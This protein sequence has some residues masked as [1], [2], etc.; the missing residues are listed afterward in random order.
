ML[1]SFLADR[2]SKNVW[3]SK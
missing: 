1:V 3:R 2:K